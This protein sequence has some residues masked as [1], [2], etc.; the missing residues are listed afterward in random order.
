MFANFHRQ[1]FCWMDKWHGWTMEDVR[2][3]E[4]QTKK[5]LEE[6]RF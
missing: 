3:H 1:V 4:E 5:E 2:I 6:V